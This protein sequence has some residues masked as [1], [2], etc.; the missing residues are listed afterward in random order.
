MFEGDWRPRPTQRMGWEHP[1][2]S[3][4]THFY[5]QTPPAS[6][7]LV[8]FLVS[9]KAHPR[10]GSIFGG[11]SF[12]SA[13]NKACLGTRS[14]FKPG[15][16]PQLLSA[17]APTNNNTCAAAVS[18]FCGFWPILFYPPSC[19]IPSH[20]PPVGVPFRTRPPCRALP[21]PQPPVPAPGSRP[22]AG[23][24]LRVPREGAAEAGAQL[25]RDAFNK[26]CW[27]LH[28]HVNGDTG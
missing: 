6:K 11:L 18:F 26:I 28:G 19:N 25:L 1:Y 23:R 16:R 7:R 22:E 10:R 3:R 4:P 5:F 2:K 8:S 13:K 14:H 21:G 9:L 24:Q 27:V 12:W 17:P 20:Q 15:R